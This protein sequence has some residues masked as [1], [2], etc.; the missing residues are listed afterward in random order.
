M[1]SI[2]K[3][4]FLIFG[5][6][7]IDK[8]SFVPDDILK[9]IAI[10]ICLMDEWDKSVTNENIE[11]TENEAACKKDKIIGWYHAY[12][13]MT[14]CQG[15]IQL[16]TVKLWPYASKW[17]IIGIIEDQCVNPKLE[18]FTDKDSHCFGYGKGLHCQDM[19]HNDELIPFDHPL[20]SDEANR[21]IKV[22]LNM[23]NKDKGVLTYY[24]HDEKQESKSYDNIDITKKYRLCIAL[25]D[26]GD[27]FT[28]IE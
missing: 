20:G 1:E 6:V 12:G 9:L 16:W 27:G 2:K 21:V 14:V 15:D 23:A 8:I 10:W 26:A 7:R 3:K 11:I 25:C 22:E 19:F 18:H 28:I 24:F 13:S 17:R 5:F 4:E